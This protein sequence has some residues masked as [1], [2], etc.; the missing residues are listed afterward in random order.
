MRFRFPNSARLKRASEFRRV[1]EQGKT[2]NGKYLLLG[3]F[4]TGGTQPAQVGLITSGR[5]GCAVERNRVRRRLRE[6]ARKTRPEILP[7]THLVIIARRSAVSA[8]FSQLEQDWLRT[9]QKAGILKGS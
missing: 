5:I 2:A 7:G 1:K 6:L 8:S 9:T 3:V 4:Q